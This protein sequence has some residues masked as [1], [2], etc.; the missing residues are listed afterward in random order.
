MSA[1]R[2]PADASRGTIGLF[3]GSFDPVHHGHLIVARVAAETLGLAELRWDKVT[4]RYFEAPDVIDIA[5]RRPE[6]YRDPE[7][8]YDA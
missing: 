3:G 4:G 6:K 7:A 2:S 8:G 5:T 1:G